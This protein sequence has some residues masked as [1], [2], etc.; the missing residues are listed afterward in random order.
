VTL[1]DVQSQRHVLPRY[2]R[3]VGQEL[4]TRRSTE[5]IQNIRARLFD[6]VPDFEGCYAGLRCLIGWIGVDFSPRLI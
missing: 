6:Q 4:R 3:I 2:L 5:A 1:P